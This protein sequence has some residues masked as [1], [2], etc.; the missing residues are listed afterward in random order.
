MVGVAE[1]TMKIKEVPPHLEL[2]MLPHKQEGSKEDPS[3]TCEN[4]E[5]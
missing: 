5:K 2:S 1:K 3:H 4:N